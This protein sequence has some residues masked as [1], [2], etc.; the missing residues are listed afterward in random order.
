MNEK[1]INGYNRSLELVEEIITQIQCIS[2]I[3]LN[4]RKETKRWKCDRS[5]K[6]NRQ[7]RKKSKVW[8]GVSE[9]QAGGEKIFRERMA[10]KFPEV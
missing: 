7:Q 2:E 4:G 6:R 5:T 9:G 10:K 3:F 1:K 8:I